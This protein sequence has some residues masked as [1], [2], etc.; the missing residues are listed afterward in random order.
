M[1]NKQKRKSP[2][3]AIIIS[4]SA[5]CNGDYKT[6][7]ASEFWNIPITISPDSGDVNVTLFA[8]SFNTNGHGTP[9]A[10]QFVEGGNTVTKPSDPTADRYAFGGW[11]KDENCTQEYDFNSSGERPS[12]ISTPL[13]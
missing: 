13:Q 2:A 10:Q 9:M 12:I 5:Q 8:V 6:D 7:Y 1:H 3:G 11:Y 4:D